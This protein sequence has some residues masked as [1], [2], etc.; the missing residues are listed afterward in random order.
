MPSKFENLDKLDRR[1]ISTLLSNGRESIAN[2]SRRIGLSRTAVAE[3]ISRLERM[4]V[5]AG[6]T[7][8]LG[9][10][11]SKPKAVC[12]LLITCSK[13]QKGKVCEY[14]EEIP[15]I[16]YASVVG[17]SFDIIS[18]VEAYSLHFAHIIC[19]RVESISGVEKVSLTVELHQAINR[20]WN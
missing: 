18:L 10:P 20:Q 13:G 3:R 7:I 17:G 14:L 2:M 6:Y 4:Q 9:K 5:I 1:I 12:Y 16:K 11:D 15:E 19:D 8:K